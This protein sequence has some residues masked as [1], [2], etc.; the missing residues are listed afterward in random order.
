M[1]TSILVSIIVVIL[2]IIAICLLCDLFKLS[3]SKRR[4]TGGKEEDIVSKGIED[5]LKIKKESTLTRS[6]D[7]IKPRQ[8]KFL[9][10]ISTKSFTI[11]KTEIPKIVPVI[12]DNNTETKS[13]SDVASKII[14]DTVPEIKVTSITDTFEK[15]LLKGENAL[16]EI[17]KTLST[18]LGNTTLSKLTPNVVNNIFSKYAE[19][20]TKNVKNIK[21]IIT[22]ITSGKTEGGWSL[23]EMAKDLTKDLTKESEK[24]ERRNNEAAAIYKVMNSKNLMTLYD[25]FMAVLDLNYLIDLF[26][27]YIDISIIGKYLN[28]VRSEVNNDINLITKLRTIKYTPHSFFELKK[29]EDFYSSNKD[30]L[31]YNL[32]E[33]SKLKMLSNYFKLLFNYFGYILSNIVCMFKIILNPTKIIALSNNPRLDRAELKRLGM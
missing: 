3:S 1:N 23:K 12:A 18:Q 24:Q 33:Y 11:S 13:F 21:G 15:I 30:K 16:S 8:S 2:L 32:E 5:S 28:I 14:V 7:T 17:F 26:K 31:P 25:T 10:D 9:T 20:I 6:S 22:T 29:Y 4:T 19:H 27:K